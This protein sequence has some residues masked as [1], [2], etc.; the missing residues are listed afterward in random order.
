MSSHLLITKE[1]LTVDEVG[2]V[3]SGDILIEKYEKLSKTGKLFKSR[4]SSKT[5]KLSKFRKSTKSR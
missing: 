5:G 2:G 4:K 1:L 3:E